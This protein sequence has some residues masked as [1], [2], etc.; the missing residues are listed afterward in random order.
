[1]LLGSFIVF[2]KSFHFFSS[3][4]INGDHL[5][6]R[7][8]VNDESDR[9]GNGRDDGK[10]DPPARSLVGVEILLPLTLFFAG[11]CRGRSGG[12]T[13]GGRGVEE[14]MDEAW[15]KGG[16]KWASTKRRGR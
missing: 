1:M 3:Q 10:N 8:V 5:G 9:G 15:G 13:S 16:I 12:I 7:S 4:I 6:P 11:F 14:A 2:A